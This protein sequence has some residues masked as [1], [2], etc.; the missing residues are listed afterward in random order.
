MNTKRNV[1]LPLLI[2]PALLAFS[3]RGDELGFHPGAGAT[4]TKTFTNDSEISLEEMSIS[5][6]GQELDPSMIG[7]M[8]MSTTSAQQVTITDEYAAMDDGRPT[9]LIRRFDKLASS[10]VVSQSNPMM[11]D[12]TTDMKSSSQLEGK[13]VIFTWNAENGEYDLAFEEGSDGEASLLEGLAVD[14]DLSGLLPDKEVAVDDTWEIDPDAVRTL[15]APGGSLKLIA[16]NFDELGMGNSPQPSADQFLGD[17]EGE[18]SGTYMGTRDEDGVKVG[19]IHL[20]IAF[21]SA[22]DLT[23]FMKEMMSE[24]EAPG[25]ED[26][27][28]EVEAFDM[29]FAFEGEGDLLWNIEAGVIHS[30]EVTGEVEQTVDMAMN[31]AMAGMEMSMENTMVMAG[32]LTIG[33]TTGSAD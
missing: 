30:I 31:L 8:E 13:T 33:V 24:V 20:K 25:G 27:N 23:E 15:F 17:M 4:L 7:N 1:L 11:G 32:S 3:S 19:V 9:K 18:V 12:S 5:Q 28:M 22:K 21:T 2:A 16:E 6:D 14:T 29:E 26:L 10:S